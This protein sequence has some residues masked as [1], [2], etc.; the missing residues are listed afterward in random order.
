MPEFVKLASD[1]GISM[2]SFGQMMANNPQEKIYT[3]LNVKDKY[4]ETL[5]KVEEFGR[6]YKVEVFY[7]RFGENLGLDQNKCVAPFNEIFIRTNGDIAPCCYF[8]DTSF[9]NVFDNDFD[10]VWFSNTGILSKI[11][12]NVI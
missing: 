11:R 10:E 4:N 8:G 7:R 9:G 3:L 2:V 12:K 1:L 6:R 5:E